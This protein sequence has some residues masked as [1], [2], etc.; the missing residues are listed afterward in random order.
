MVAGVGQFALFKGRDGFFRVGKIFVVGDHH[1][2]ML[3]GHAGKG[4]DYGVLAHVARNDHQGVVVAQVVHLVIVVQF[5][6]D[7][8]QY[9]AILDVGHLIHGSVHD[10]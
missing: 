7:R 2:L 1:H 4:V 6:V 10:G 8:I 3:A 9:L 5:L